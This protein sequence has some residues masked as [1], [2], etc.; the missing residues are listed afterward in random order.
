V[1][2][3]YPIYDPKWAKS[4]PYLRSKGLKTLLFGAAHAY[5]AHIRECSPMA[6]DGEKRL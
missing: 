2:K 4:T 1:K 3:P 5:I 6:S